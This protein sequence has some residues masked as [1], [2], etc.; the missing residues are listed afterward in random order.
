[1][2]LFAYLLFV[3]M[4]TNALA[5]PPNALPSGPITCDVFYEALTR[6]LTWRD[7]FND[8]WGGLLFWNRTGYKF[9]KRGTASLRRVPSLIR[10]D[11]SNSL[12]SDKT[13][14]ALA[15]KLAE[16][17]TE[18]QALGTGVLGQQALDY[19]TARNLTGLNMLKIEL[20]RLSVLQRFVK[21][22]RLFKQKIP[23]DGQMK[24][25]SILEKKS[26]TQILSTNS[27]TEKIKQLN[28][29]FDKMR[30]NALDMYLVGVDYKTLETAVALKGYGTAQLR[31]EQIPEKRDKIVM[32]IKFTHTEVVS[33][34][35]ANGRLR[36]LNDVVNE[37]RIRLSMKFAEF[38]GKDFEWDIIH[39]FQPGE[40]Y[41]TKTYG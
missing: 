33:N 3:T 25:L 28:K 18:G 19:A 29:F 26:L 21:P 31:A 16:M 35:Y 23:T 20:D 41:L 32:T 24:D 34:A 40:D 38:R 7:Y 13:R 37:L 14:I 10:E 36:K 12:R 17:H 15:K 8:G 39:T 11:T 27:R 6:K 9:F 1:M 4:A 2:R 5:A 22:G 30:E